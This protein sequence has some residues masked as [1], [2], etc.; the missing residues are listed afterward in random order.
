MPE[1]EVIKRMLN[2]TDSRF[3]K[4]LLNKSK[5]AGKLEKDYQIPEEY[6]N[7]FPEKIAELLKPYQDHGYFKI[8]PFGTDLTDDDVALGSSLKVMKALGESSKLKLAAGLL[9][10]FFKPA[11]ASAAHHLKRMKLDKPGSLKERIYRKMILFAL[12]NNGKI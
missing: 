12:R 1:S 11:P 6:R 7:N 2:I 10:E 3:Q 8:F 4:Q 5:K 9:S